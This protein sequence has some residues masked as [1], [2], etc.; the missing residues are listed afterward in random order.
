MLSDRASKSKEKSGYS[1]VEFFVAGDLSLHQRQQ[2]QMF[3]IHL[4]NV[5]LLHFFVLIQRNEAKKNQ[6]KPDRSARF[7]W[8]VL[9]NKINFVYRKLNSKQPNLKLTIL[10]P[11]SIINNLQAQ[12]CEA[13]PQT[14]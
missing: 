6:G 3:G 4:T 1:Y 7:A 5:F 12:I 10:N 2:L 14:Y 8:L 11:I 9:V 13:E